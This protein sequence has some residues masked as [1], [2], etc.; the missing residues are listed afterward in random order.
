MKVVQKLLEKD[1]KKRYQTAAQA[2][3]DLKIIFEML[4][5]IECW[6]GLERGRHVGRDHSRKTVHRPPGQP[7]SRARFSEGFS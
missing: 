2:R 4:A 5:E 7:R 3:D 1:L 6:F